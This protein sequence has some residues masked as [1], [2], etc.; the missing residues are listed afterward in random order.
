[1]I[2]CCRNNVEREGVVGGRGV[3]DRGRG[4]IL[5]SLMMLMII[6]L[7]VMLD[8]KGSFERLIN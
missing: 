4:G 1:M 3:R 2:G 8:R 7:G 6:W 5:D